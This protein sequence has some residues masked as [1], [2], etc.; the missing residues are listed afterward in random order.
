MKENV[1]KIPQIS[2]FREPEKIT[3]MGKKKRVSSYKPAAENVHQAGGNVLSYHIQTP[4]C[5]HIIRSVTQTKCQD[6]ILYYRM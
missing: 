4:A 2:G 6:A 5:S 1:C 3:D